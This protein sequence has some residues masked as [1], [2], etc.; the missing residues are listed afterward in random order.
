MQRAELNEWI[1]HAPKF[2]MCVF[3]PHKTPDRWAAT[4]SKDL[5]RAIQ[6]DDNIRNLDE[7]GLT[8]GPAYLSDRLIPI[9]NLSR[10]NPSTDDLKGTDGCEGGRC[11]L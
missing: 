8:D 4:E 9:R 10:E 1:G 7:F 3:C 11:F 2:S 6:V 5:E